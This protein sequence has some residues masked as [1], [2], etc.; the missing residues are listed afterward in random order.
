[1]NHQYWQIKNVNPYHSA[2][3]DRT[4]KRCV[5]TTDPVTHTVYL[6]KNLYGNFKIRVFVHELAHCTMI[7]YGLIEAIHRMVLPEYWVD[8]EEFICNIIAD[9]GLNMLKIAYRFFG[10]RALYYLP[11]EMGRF[12]S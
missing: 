8:M 4:N 9:Y 6:S 3:V 7:S 11:E 1:M 10:E 2:L 12:V 5:A